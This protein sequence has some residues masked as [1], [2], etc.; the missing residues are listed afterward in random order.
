[1]TKRPPLVG[2]S[3]LFERG[4]SLSVPIDAA[5]LKQGLFMPE[6]GKVV[7]GGMRPNSDLTFAPRGTQ[8]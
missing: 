5:A 8:P 7:R 1:M 2:A 3:A 6:G 4:K